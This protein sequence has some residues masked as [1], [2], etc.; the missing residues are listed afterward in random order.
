MKQI[1]RLTESDL[2]RLVKESVQKILNEVSEAK[3]KYAGET[4]DPDDP[5]D[6]IT[7]YHLRHR[8]A[9]DQDNLEDV[10]RQNI[11]GNKDRETGIH[12]GWGDYGKFDRGE[13]KANRIIPRTRPQ[14]AIETGKKLEAMLFDAIEKY[15]EGG[16]NTN[17]WG[18]YVYVKT[19][20]YDGNLMVYL[21]RG[22]TAKKLWDAIDY[23]YRNKI[24]G[25]K[26]D[27][28][29][30]HLFAYVP[31]FDEDAQNEWDA[32]VNKYQQGVKDYYNS[33]KSGEY[34]GD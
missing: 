27:V 17:K 29:N 33:K 23:K 5:A 6:W 21:D 11:I 22:D 10:R 31:Y 32:G 16:Y 26:P 8:K 12:L 2:H 7:L 30:G 15:G 20:T 28:Y 1:I 19:G 4:L 14:N 9:K 3:H 24:V 18:K 13:E 25:F 34:T